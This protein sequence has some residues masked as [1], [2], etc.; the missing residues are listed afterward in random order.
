MQKNVI[1]MPKYLDYQELYPY[2]LFGAI[3]LL[4]AEVV[5]ANTVLRRLP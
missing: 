4:L 5:L 3:G 2:F 1:K